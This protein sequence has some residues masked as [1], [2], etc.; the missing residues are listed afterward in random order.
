MI[1]DVR[2]KDCYM[3]L[4]YYLIDFDNLKK[5]QISEQIINYLYIK[6]SV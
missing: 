1:I 5:S 3:F 2:S 6:N 4:S